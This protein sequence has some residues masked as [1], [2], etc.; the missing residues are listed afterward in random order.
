MKIIGKLPKKIDFVYLAGPLTTGSLPA[1][2]REMCKFADKLMDRGFFPFNPAGSHLQDLICRKH[3]SAWLRYDFNMLARMGFVLRMP[4][5]SK[6]AD[7]EV[8]F[9]RK[10]KIPVVILER[11]EEIEDFCGMYSPNNEDTL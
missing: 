5:K 9:A 3:Y 10:H 2:I 7:L 6:G 11:R 1:N 4:G 8:K